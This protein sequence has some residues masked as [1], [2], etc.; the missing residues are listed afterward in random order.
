M[1]IQVDYE[2]VSASANYGGA[3]VLN[4]ESSDNHFKVDIVTTKV[5]DTADPNKN[6][7]KT[8]FNVDLYSKLGLGLKVNENSVGF[9]AGFDIDVKDVKFKDLDLDKNI[10]VEPKAATINGRYVNPQLFYEVTKS[11]IEGMVKED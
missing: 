4:V 7:S 1:S 3:V 5:K 2:K 9:V 11:I 10:E 8:T 6:S